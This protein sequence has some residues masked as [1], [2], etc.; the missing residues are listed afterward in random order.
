MHIE[1]P[2]LGGKHILWKTV[3]YLKMWLLSEGDIKNGE[4]FTMAE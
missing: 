2:T 1:I 4:D 3:L